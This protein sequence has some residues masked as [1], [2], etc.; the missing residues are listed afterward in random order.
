MFPLLEGGKNIS[1]MEGKLVKYTSWWFQ[2]C[3]I[4]TP[5]W[6]DNPN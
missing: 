2:I 5:T 6:G 4:F 3:F 1:S